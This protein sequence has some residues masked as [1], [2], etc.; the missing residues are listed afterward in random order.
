MNEI[1]KNKLEILANDPTTLSAISKLFSGVIETYKPEIDEKK[2]NQLLG[3]QYRAYE[4][5]KKTVGQA[6][7][8]IGLYQKR[9]INKKNFIKAR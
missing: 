2:D 4:L 7:L 9:D 5:A 3:E 1:E 8:E 6:L